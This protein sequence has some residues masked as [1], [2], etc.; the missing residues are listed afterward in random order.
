MRWCKDN[1]L[2]PSMISRG[3]CYDI[4]V[5]ESFFSSLKKGAYKAKHLPNKGEI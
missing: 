4:A 3:N 2:V 5:A 1:N